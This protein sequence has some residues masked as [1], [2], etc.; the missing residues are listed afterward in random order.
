MF[1]LNISLLY[2]CLS[3]SLSDL[4]ANSKAML[5]IYVKTAKRTAPF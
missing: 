5:I 2:I 1:D 4:I 3:L